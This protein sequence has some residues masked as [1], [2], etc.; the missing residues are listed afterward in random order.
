MIAAGAT[1][2][3]SAERAPAGRGS[4]VKWVGTSPALCNRGTCRCR[5]SSSKS[6]DQPSGREVTR[7]SFGITHLHHAFLR[8][9][10]SVVACGGKRVAARARGADVGE[11]R[12]MGGPSLY[13]P[14]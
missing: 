13:E 14:M 7:N 5:C 1:R 4:P 10:V 6:L 12:V 8:R 2:R 9:R 3:G 11:T